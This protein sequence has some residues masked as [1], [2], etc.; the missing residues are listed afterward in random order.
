MNVRHSAEKTSFLLLSTKWGGGPR[1]G[2]GVS[3]DFDKVTRR[4]G[5]FKIIRKVGGNFAYLYPSTASRSPSPL[6]GEEGVRNLSRDSSKNL[7]HKNAQY[8]VAA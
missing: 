7:T 8:G 5:L 3:S 2:G 1:S 4:R 6:R